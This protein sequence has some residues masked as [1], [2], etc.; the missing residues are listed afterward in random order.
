LGG[1]FAYPDYG[2]KREDL[3][4]EIAFGRDNDHELIIFDG[5]GE[6]EHVF[7]Y[8]MFY[9]EFCVEMESFGERPLY[10]SIH[11]LQSSF[12]PVG[13]KIIAGVFFGFLLLLQQDSQQ[14]Y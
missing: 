1:K 12:F 5:E 11:H 3:N 10:A 4:F 7:C 13:Y 8:Q 2:A 6:E 9:I 14:F